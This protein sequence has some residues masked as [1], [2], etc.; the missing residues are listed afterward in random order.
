MNQ[1][2]QTRNTARLQLD[3]PMASDLA[4]LCRMEQDVT[5]MSTLG[6]TCEPHETEARLGRLM[7]HWE[8]HG[9]GWWIVRDRQRRAFMGRG[10]L[11]WVE[12][13]GRLEVEV[14][15]GFLAPFWNQ[16]F[17]TELA[18]ESVAIAFDTLELASVVSFTLPTN[19]AS[20]RVMEK[21]GLGYERDFVWA[22]RPHVLY[23]RTKKDPHGTGPGGL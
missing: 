23:R 1:A 10:G 19:A 15:Y 12:V 18:R 4:E 11:R 14:G 16:G 6:G 13:N 9:F 8:Q 7:A 20:R 5:T 22:G 2:L 21:A 3:R 17:A